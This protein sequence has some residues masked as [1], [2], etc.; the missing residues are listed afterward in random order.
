MQ[1]D[2]HGRRGTASIRHAHV[3]DGFA[4]PALDRFA[5]KPPGARL[6]HESR[7][8]GDD[9][10]RDDTQSRDDASRAEQGVCGAVQEAASR[11][12]VDGVS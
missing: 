2:K 7:H 11:V 8:E 9:E 12:P 3:K 6:V 5:N 4:E 1:A 10:G